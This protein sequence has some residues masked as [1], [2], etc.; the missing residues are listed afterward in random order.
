ML[1]RMLAGMGIEPE[2]LRLEWISA[3]EGEKVR[4]VVNEMVDA[5]KRLG[6]LSM[7]AKIRGVGPG[8]GTF[9][10][11]IAAQM[12]PPDSCAEHGTQPQTVETAHA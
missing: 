12:P 8:D 1:K 10:Q 6:P 9:R 5:L 2:R 4:R 11:H 7:P 3:A